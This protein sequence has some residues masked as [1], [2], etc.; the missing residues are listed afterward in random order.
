MIRGL[1]TG[2]SG[3]TAMQTKMD[4]TANN[5]ANVDKTAFKQDTVIF[6]N[7][8]ELL[9]HRT[10]DDGVGWTPMGSFDISPLVGK[11]GTGSEVNEIFTRFEQGTLKKTDK[12]S[13]L[14][15]NGEGFFVV[16]TNR[17]PR[18][19][20]SGAFVV[21]TEGY[22]V[23]PNGFSLMGEKGPIQ[24]ARHNFSIR[25]NGEVWIND[26]IGNDPRE[27]WGTDTN[28]W[29]QPRLLD[30]LQLREVDYPRHLLKEGE[31]FYMT[32]PE[33]GDMRELAG[34]KPTEILQGYLETSNVNIVTEMVN[35]IEVQRMYEANQKSVMTHDSMLGVLINTV[36]RSQ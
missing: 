4:V 15:I 34:N 12:E 28:H 10:N 5:L 9:L 1:Y 19:T 24:V 23:T 18:M 31:S 22:L 25:D 21:N 11:L 16:Q 2:A 29:E 6:K 14:A 17:G 7:F 26:M 36:L 27:V 8:P 20:R 32:T 30:K 33:S 35:M 3:M 13:D